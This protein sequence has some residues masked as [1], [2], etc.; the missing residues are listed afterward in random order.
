MPSTKSEIAKL[1]EA[2]PPSPPVESLIA[3]GFNEELGNAD[4][5]TLL[6]LDAGTLEVICRLNLPGVSLERLSI[7]EEFIDEPLGFEQVVHF[8]CGASFRPFRLKVTQCI[9]HD[10]A[11]RA[12]KRALCLLTSPHKLGNYAAESEGGTIKIW[13]RWTTVVQVSSASVVLK[14]FEK[15]CVDIQALAAVLDNAMKVHKGTIAKVPK[16]GLHNDFTLANYYETDII[17]VIFGDGIHRHREYRVIQHEKTCVVE[18]DVAGEYGNGDIAGGRFNSHLTVYPDKEHKEVS[19]KIAVLMAHKTSL[20]PV[21]EKLDL[22][23][24]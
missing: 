2:P 12:M 13:T 24:D 15:P 8:S 17:K 4:N 10:G 21:R 1:L 18:D 9:S 6:P 22:E 14:D 20:W 11:I 7:G 3:E 5:T 16:A 19:A 23:D